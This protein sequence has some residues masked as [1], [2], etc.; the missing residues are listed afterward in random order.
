MYLLIRCKCGR[1]LYA[2]KNQKTRSCPC[3]KILKINK[4]QVYARVRTE[5]EAGEAVRILQ[6]KEFG[7]PGF[8]RYDI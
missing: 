1:F 3:G 8:R 2:N 5:Q 4:M 7:V 6:E